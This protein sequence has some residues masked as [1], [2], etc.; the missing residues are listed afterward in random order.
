ML[1]VGSFFGRGF[2]SRRLHHFLSKH[3]IFWLGGEVFLQGF[4]RKTVVWRWFFVV[5][6]WSRYGVFVVLKRT[7]LVAENLSSF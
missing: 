5:F 7:F 2:D 1:S 4:L 3:Q 6:L